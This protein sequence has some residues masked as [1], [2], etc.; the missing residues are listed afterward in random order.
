MVRSSPFFRGNWARSL[1][2]KFGG[3]PSPVAAYAHIEDANIDLRSFFS[4]WSTRDWA[5]FWTIWVERNARSIR[6]MYD[7]QASLIRTVNW[8]NSALS[9][10]N[11]NAHSQQETRLVGWNPSG[12]RDYVLH[13]DGSSFGNPGKA[14]FGAVIW[15]AEG[16]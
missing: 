2:N 7:D 10:A 5:T 8:R 13:V 14:G 11:A 9:R 1:W 12:Y 3:L 6:G 15:D 16:N 4:H